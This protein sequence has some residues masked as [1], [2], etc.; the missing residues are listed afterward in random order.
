[1]KK[2]REILSQDFVDR[3][4]GF[5]WLDTGWGCG[6]IIVKKKT[7]VETTSIFKRFRGYPVEFTTLLQKDKGGIRMN[8]T[9]IVEEF[10][11]VN[12]Y[13]GLYSNIGECGCGLD[14]L[15]PYGEQTNL[16]DC[17]PVIKSH[18]TVKR[19]AIFI[20]ARNQTRLRSE[21]LK[22]SIAF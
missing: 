16:I 12:G 7:I 21:C 2:I 10:L 13:D 1:M 11:R 9:K 18:V 5:Y 6:G 14:D 20:L 19:A 15:V 17:E 8:L 3:R 22:N 4:D